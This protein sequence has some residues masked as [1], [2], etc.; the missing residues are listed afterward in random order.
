VWVLI[1]NPNY[2]R[3]KFS[4]VLELGT[5]GLITGT[6]F[7]ADGSTPQVDATVRL[8]PGGPATQSTAGGAFHMEGIPKGTYHII[9]YHGGFQDDEDIE[10]DTDATTNV[11]FSLAGTL[12][13]C[14]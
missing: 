6:V 8:C 14:P 7:K 1:K 10:V 5:T 11:T 3:H 2:W 12:K 4:D 9:A 13:G